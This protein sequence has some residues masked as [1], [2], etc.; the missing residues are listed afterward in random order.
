MKHPLNRGVRLVSPM[1]RIFYRFFG[2]SN[3]RG[4]ADYHCV[5]ERRGTLWVHCHGSAR[6]GGAN[7]EFVGVPP[8][9]RGTALQLMFGLVAQM[10]AGR[11]L[12]ADEGFAAPL[13][14]SRQGFM[15]IGTLR[16]TA[17]SDRH[18]TGMLRV[19]DYGEPL[20]SGFPVRLFASH[21]VAR[22]ERVENPE[23]KAAMCRRSI[24]LFA[25]DFV[26]AIG[27][28]ATDGADADITELQ[29]KC[30]VLAYAGLA[31]ALCAQN[32]HNE[33]CGIIVEAIARCPP[34]ARGYRDRLLEAG[35]PEDQYA[36]FWH[37][38]DIAETVM[39][40]RPADGAAPA[41][42]AAP[43]TQ[44]DGGFGSRAPDPYDDL[45][46]RG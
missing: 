8:E 18:H 4:W 22:A 19:V 10:R 45:L 23:R 43:R 3:P 5:R 13:A 34:W 30:N 37:D 7:L 9:L 11:K 16:A 39:R 26:D 28:P 35:A 2:R 36:R 42:Q 29:N 17:W 6:R 21:L 40:Y 15:Q 24:E 38:M 31:D 25:G 14:S 1:A 32:R 44:G 20:Q 12:R 41:T 46:R 33:A 27:G